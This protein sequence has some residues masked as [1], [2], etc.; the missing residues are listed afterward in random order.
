MY[1]TSLS[2]G[3]GDAVFL[4]DSAAD[5]SSGSHPYSVSGQRCVFGIVLLEQGYRQQAAS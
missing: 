2:G 4:R 1:N 3:K 5:G